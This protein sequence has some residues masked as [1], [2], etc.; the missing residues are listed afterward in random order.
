MIIVNYRCVSHKVDH[1]VIDEGELA[2]HGVS[3]STILA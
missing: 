3:E 2:L 1:T